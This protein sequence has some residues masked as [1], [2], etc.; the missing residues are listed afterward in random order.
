MAS[1]LSLILLYLVAAVAGVVLCRSLKLPQPCYL[2]VSVL[3]GPML[4]WRDSAAV[5]CWPGSVSCS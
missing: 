5:A 4:L 2:A 3:I 1:T